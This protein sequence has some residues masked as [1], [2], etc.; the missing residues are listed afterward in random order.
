MLRIL[1]ICSG[2]TCRSPMAEALFKAKCEESGLADQ[3]NI[4]SAGT[5]ALGSAPAS[6]GALRAM[7]RR[8]LDLASHRARQLEPEF[9]QAADLILTMTKAHKNTVLSFMPEAAEKVYTL[10]EFAGVEQDIADPFGGSD[11]IYEVCATNIRELLD[12]AWEK[13]ADLAGKK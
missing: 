9:V 11:E 2:N 7:S 1:L 6:G 5:H 8:G 13:I 4:L 10:A 12:N 3:I